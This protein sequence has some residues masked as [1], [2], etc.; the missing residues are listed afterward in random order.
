MTNPIDVSRIPANALTSAESLI[1]YLITGL[2]EIHPSSSAPEEEGVEPIKRVIAIVQETPGNSGGQHW[3][4]RV[5]FELDQ[6]SGRNSTWTSVQ[7]IGD[8]DFPY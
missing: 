1:T 2:K 7:S 5:R 6:S 8:V 3:V 4:G